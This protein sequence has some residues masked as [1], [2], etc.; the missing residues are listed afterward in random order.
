MA[1]ILRAMAV[2]SVLLSLLVCHCATRWLLTKCVS[3]WSWATASIR[4][5]ASCMPF[6]TGRKKSSFTQVVANP[7]PGVDAALVIA[8]SDKRGSIYGIYDLS[9]ESGQ[10]P[11]YYWGDV[12]TKKH[13]ELYVKAGKYQVGEPSVKYRGIFINDEDWGLQ[14]WAAKTF[15]PEIGSLGPKTYARVFELLLRLRANCI[16]PGATSCQPAGTFQFGLSS[17]VAGAGDGVSQ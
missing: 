6:F 3:S 1:W 12:P 7:L 11:W 5:A 16:W 13:A 17:P 4:S 9:E 10:S 14:P 15:E 8:G 2:A